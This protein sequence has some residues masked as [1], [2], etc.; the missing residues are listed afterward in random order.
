MISQDDY[1]F[2]TKLDNSVADA[3]AQLL[4]EKPYQVCAREEFN[5]MKN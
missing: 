3:R 2:I 5:V 4:K 1:S